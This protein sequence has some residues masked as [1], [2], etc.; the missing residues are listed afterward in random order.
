M[1]KD[2]QININMST[3]QERFLPSGHSLCTNVLHAFQ[4]GLVMQ[5]CSGG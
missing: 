1:H 5:T 3:S 2:M 4:T